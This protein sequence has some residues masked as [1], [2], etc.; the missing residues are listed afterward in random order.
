MSGRS[1]RVYVC[2]L[3]GCTACSS[4]M[5]VVWRLQAVWSDEADVAGLLDL[6][7]LVQVNSTIGM[8]L[9]ECEQAVV[10]SF[11]FAL[12]LFCAHKV[13]CLRHDIHIFSAFFLSGVVFYTLLPVSYNGWNPNLPCGCVRI[14]CLIQTLALLVL[15]GVL[16]ETSNG[17]HMQYWKGTP[18]RV[19]FGS[20]IW[21]WRSNV[22]NMLWI[23]AWTRLITPFLCGF[24][25]VE[26]LACIS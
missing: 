2:R 13:L 16:C 12:F 25:M 7:A 8:N 26:G 3:W 6:V 23:F 9:S 1:L 15:L 10:G 18:V 17:Q 5:A 11:A 4:P 19:L 21:S 22:Q 24:Q 14:E 20:N